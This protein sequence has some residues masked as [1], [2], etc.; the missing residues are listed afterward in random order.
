M[1]PHEVLGIS[2]GASPDQIKAAYRKK[3]KECHPDRNPGDTDAPRRFCEVQDAYESLTDPNWRPPRHRPSTSSTPSQG[4]KATY[5]PPKSRPGSWIKDAPPPTH[6]IWGDPING[7]VDQP[8]PKP[9]PKPRPRPEPVKPEPEVD[10]WDQ[11]ETKAGRASRS[12]WK[13]YE[14]LKKVMAYEDPDK[15]WEAMD[16]WARKNKLAFRPGG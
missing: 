16:D 15:F 11:L 5:S 9:K 2:P 8:R 13:E 10:L 14:R 7:H 1:G 4:Y 6:D 12:Y 3:V